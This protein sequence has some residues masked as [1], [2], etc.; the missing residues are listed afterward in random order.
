MLFLFNVVITNDNK[1]IRY[2]FQNI[3][4]MKKYVVLFLL[5]TLKLFSQNT[6]FVG[7]K[8]YLTTSK[9]TFKTK[10][11]KDDY[12]VFY[13]AKDGNKG[14]FVVNAEISYG[15][16]IGGTLIIYLEDNSTIQCKDR[17]IRDLTN[18]ECTTIYYLTPIEIE[19]MKK[20]KI[21]N[22]RYNT[23]FNNH[24]E[25]AFIARNIYQINDS[26]IQSYFS[27]KL[28]KKEFYETDIEIQQL[29][30]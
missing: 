1:T 20:H 6:L 4:I 16:I 8:T 24:H 7:D 26:E 27:G 2:K 30:N 15:E 12:P 28:I 11:S 10:L 21:M 18:G 14:L 13:V 5:I 9:W 3:K 29:F 22:V 23:M 19:R 25:Q 17:G